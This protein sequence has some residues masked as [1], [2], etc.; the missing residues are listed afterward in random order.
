LID[1]KSKIFSVFINVFLK[2]VVEQ[3]A[4]VQIVRKLEAAT[5]S[6]KF[7]LKL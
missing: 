7:F 5:F 2:E 3:R 6:Q 1:E 4:K